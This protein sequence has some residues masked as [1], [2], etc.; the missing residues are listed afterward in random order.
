ME[1]FVTCSQGLEPLL[2]DELQAL[3]CQNLRT[4]YRGVYVPEATLEDIYRINYCS[5]LG[6][7]VLMPLSRFRC[8]HRDGLYRGIAELDWMPLIPDNKTFA[9]DANVTHK[10]LRNSLYAAQV[11]KDA[12]CDQLRDQRGR[13]PNIDP[14]NPDIQLNLF[15]REPWATIYLDTSGKPLYK[16][17]YRVERGEAPMQETLAAALL[18]L[19]GYTS[20]EILC[21]PCCGSGTL[22]IEA[23]LMAAAI[24]P[25]FLRT[26]WG[27]RFHPE[28][29]QA[30]W[31][32]VKAEADR[33]RKTLEPGRFFGCDANKEVVRNCKANLRAAGLQKAIE[34]VASDFRDYTPPIPPTF[35]IANPPHGRRLGEADRL[36]PIYRA[37]G[38]FLKSKTAKP[39]RAFVFIGDMA[40]T[41]EMGLASKRRHVI[42]NN[43]VDSRLLEFDVF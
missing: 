37:L 32:K 27:F 19:A 35:V 17:G 21:D 22:L 29:S 6:G 15:I 10:E 5:R 14:T 33:H 16:R 40:L 34:V 25:G 23:A 8:P 26:E 13:R 31:L 41:K 20:S 1:L 30:L 43:G 3:G 38:D 18:T 4:G 7:R 12:I 42:D 9:I 11:T 2:I 36:Q 24:P 39:A 28:F